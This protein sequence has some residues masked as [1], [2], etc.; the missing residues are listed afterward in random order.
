M[1]LDGDTLLIIEREFE[2][3]PVSAA[4][5]SRV[6]EAYADTD[7]Q[8]RPDQ[9]PEHKPAIAT[10]AIDVDGYL[11]VA[12]VMGEG[13]AFDVFDP[14]GYYLG[15]IE[16]PVAFV[17]NAAAPALRIGRDA[18]YG[19]TRDSLDVEYVVRIRITGRR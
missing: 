1:T 3:V 18:L 12:P 8:L 5:R 14:E 19:V 10:F 2:P 13:E 6:V 17:M 4:E 16:S 15:Q 9:I 7:W 11:W